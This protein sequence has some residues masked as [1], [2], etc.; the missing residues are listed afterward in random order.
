MTLITTIF[1]AC[2]VGCSA[3]PMADDSSI[4]RFLHRVPGPLMRKMDPEVTPDIFDYREG[5]G[6]PSFSSNDWGVLIATTFGL[7]FLD[8]MVLRRFYG[9]SWWANISLVVFW[10]LVA[11]VYNGHYWYSHGPAQGQQWATGYLLEWMLSIDNV[12]VFHLIFR[13]Y[14]TPQRQR[15]E[16]LFYGVLGA[17]VL[18]MLLYFALGACMAHFMAV[19][20]VLAII[21]IY[22]AIASTC[23]SS[24]DDNLE[25][26]YAVTILRYLIGSRLSATYET[27]SK[28]FLIHEGRIQVTML[29]FVVF[30]VEVTDVVF[31]VDSVTAKTSQLD[32]QFAA[33]SSTVLATLAL[34]AMFFVLN[35]MMEMCGMLQYGVSIILIFIGFEVVLSPWVELRSETVL[36]VISSVFAVCMTGQLALS[37]LHWWYGTESEGPSDMTKKKIEKAYS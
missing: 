12:F 11:A 16:A 33:Y 14:S 3:I 25:D 7:L 28:L 24:D 9:K 5:S 26:T 35:D 10:L 30:C 18:K 36:F 17:M 15:H 20:F 2:V 34:R 19:R 13:A 31:A 8:Y 27:T 22:S 37:S 32:D 21:L 6:F 23:W 29:F 1:A 4:V